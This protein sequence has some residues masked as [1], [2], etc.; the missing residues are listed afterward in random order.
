MHVT[1]FC[2]SCIHSTTQEGTALFIE[3]SIAECHSSDFVSNQDGVC[4]AMMTECCEHSLH[5]MH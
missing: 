3:G 2:M 5:I 4:M 1:A